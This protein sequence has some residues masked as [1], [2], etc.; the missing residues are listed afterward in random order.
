MPY[1]EFDRARIRYEMTGDGPPLVQV[2][3]AA[4]GLQGYARITPLMSRSFTVLDFDPQGYG[5]S[6]RSVD[7]YGF[8]VWARDMANLIEHVGFD[9]FVLHGGSM[10]S[11]L[12]LDFTA[13][14]PGRVTHLV[15]SG[16]TAKLDTMSKA[17]FRTWKA[18]ARAYGIGSRELADCMASHS[19]TRDFLDGPAG[20]EDFIDQLAA[21]VAETV[22][23]EAFLGACDYLIGVDVTSYLP[24]ITA[25]TL[26]MV[27][28]QDAITPADQGPT[29]AGAR[30]IYEGLV[31][32][33]RKEFLLLEGSAH[34]NLRD[35]PE[36]CA[37]A[38]QEFVAGSR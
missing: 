20:G 29:G 16:C 6:S 10:G 28:D 26:V 7:G 12:A 37:Y 33:Q 27:G 30:A 19:L 2:P 18:L 38:I 21:Q 35:V 3:G 31:S 15:L 4:T 25:P 23:L 32:C 22:A 5:R 34:S 13:R 36:T 11:T 9:E 17:Q 1:A 14:N 8:E 24:Q